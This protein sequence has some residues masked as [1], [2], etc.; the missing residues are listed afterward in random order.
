MATTPVA[1]DSSDA[2]DGGKDGGISVATAAI[3][4]GLL[5][6]LFVLGISVY[7]CCCRRDEASVDVGFSL[8]ND[9]ILSKVDNVVYAHPLQHTNHLDGEMY[10]DMP[11]KN[12]AGGQ[13]YEPMDVEGGGSYEYMS[14][15]GNTG[16]RNMA[17]SDEQDYEVVGNT[18]IFTIPFT[19]GKPGQGDATEDYGVVARHHTPAGADPDHYGPIRETKWMNT[20]ESVYVQ[21]GVGL[22]QDEGGYSDSEIHTRAGP[23][24]QYDVAIEDEADGSGAYD[25]VA[26][27]GE[28]Q[29][30]AGRDRANSSASSLGGFGMGRD[31]ASSNASSLGGFGGDAD[32]YENTTAAGAG[33]RP[34][35]KHAYI[36]DSIVLEN[37]HEENDVHA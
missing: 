12:A 21:P 30:S 29:A 13:D 6:G 7:C 23:E 10:E 20:P 17:A 35:K 34:L 31:R 22:T 32:A 9:A 33:S 1:A 26:G 3:G 8:K 18:A 37:A 5:I 14:A 19:A 36:N 16:V 24:P 4:V 2:G 28:Q 15:N 27:D 11:S 25:N